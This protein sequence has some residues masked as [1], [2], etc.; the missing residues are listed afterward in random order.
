MATA[1]NIPNHS[2]SING[3]Q[4]DSQLEYSSEEEGCL[5]PY[6]CSSDDEECH[7]DLVDEMPAFSTQS[8][9]PSGRSLS[10]IDL[11]TS[12]PRSRNSTPCNTP[13]D[14]SAPHPPVGRD[15]VSLEEVNARIGLTPP[16]D[17]RARNLETIFEDKFLE[18]PPGREFE[19][20]SNQNLLRKS[21]RNRGS[22]AAGDSTAGP[23]AA[24]SQQSMANGG[25]SDDKRFDGKRRLSL[26]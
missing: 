18:T 23:A 9:S 7:R 5:S 22:K 21:L 17:V 16:P 6:C 15:F 13:I 8:L 20:R 10:P 14:G 24:S 3:S 4:M 19:S 11:D 1:G 25:A 12:P 26:E 2:S